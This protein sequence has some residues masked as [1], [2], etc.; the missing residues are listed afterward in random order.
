MDM[1]QSM[2]IKYPLSLDIFCVFI[3]F[4]NLSCKHAII[5]L[6]P[7]ITISQTPFI[8]ML[9]LSFLESNFHLI[10][11]TPLGNISFTMII[12]SSTKYIYSSNYPLAINLLFVIILKF[13]IFFNPSIVKP[14]YYLYRYLYTSGLIITIANPSCR[15]FRSF[16]M[17]IGL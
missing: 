8:I 16:I 7:A 4:D 3:C 5:T 14:M 17:P 12:S 15:L 6:N 11:S 10:Q 2:F 13:Y 9:Y 1:H